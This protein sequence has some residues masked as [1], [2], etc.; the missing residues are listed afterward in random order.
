[1]IQWE[2]GGLQLRREYSLKPK[3]AEAL[4]LDFQP[5]KLSNKFLL[6]VNPL[7]YDSLDSSFIYDSL[8][9]ETV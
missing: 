9:L 2:V 1:M 5:P 6:F 7:V 3:N 8:N 4:I